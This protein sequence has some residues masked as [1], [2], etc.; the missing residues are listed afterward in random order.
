[1]KIP[2]TNAIK[3]EAE[4]FCFRT[5]YET[6]IAKFDDK[7]WNTA[8]LLSASQQHQLGFV[9]VGF[10]AVR[11]EP[12]ITGG[13]N[14]FQPCYQALEQRF[15]A[16]NQKLG[17]I[18]VLDHHSIT[19]VQSKVVGKHAEEQGAQRR[20]LKIPDAVGKPSRDFSGPMSASDADSLGVIL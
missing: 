19:G 7:W 10:K 3:E 14:T 1:M 13:E 9:Y 4:I 12:L 5:W 15:R 18:R 6:V 11:A 8:H 2:A 16:A 20:S 17:V